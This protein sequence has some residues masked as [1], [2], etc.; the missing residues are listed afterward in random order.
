MSGLIQTTKT[1]TMA[2]LTTEA[3]NKDIAESLAAKVFAQ[4]GVTQGLDILEQ[5]NHVY[6]SNIKAHYHN[7]KTQFQEATNHAQRAGLSTDDM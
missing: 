4:Y 2:E 3:T 7:M 6:R 5:I 1:I